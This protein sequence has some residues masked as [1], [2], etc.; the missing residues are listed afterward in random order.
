MISPPRVSWWC[1]PEGQNDVL[2]VSRKQT[3]SAA[4]CLSRVY[5]DGL[6]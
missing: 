5:P 2:D 4:G 6:E 1:L 3:V